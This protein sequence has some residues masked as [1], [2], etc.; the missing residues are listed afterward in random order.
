MP[1]LKQPNHP[2]AH[3][4][5][6][7][8][9]QRKALEK[10]HRRRTILEAAEAVMQESGLFGLNIDLVAARTELAKGTIYLYFKSK[11]E[12]LA[13]LTLKARRLLVEAFD[14]VVSRETDPLSAIRGIIR[15][16]YTFYQ[17][18]ALYYDLVSLYQAN[19]TLTETPQL[20][21][22]SKAIID[23][24]VK[25][26]GEAKTAGQVRADL[27]PVAFALCLWG[28]TVGMMQLI[29]VKSNLVEAEYNLKASQLI[30]TYVRIMV[31][32]IA[33]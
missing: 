17:K 7:S 15:A 3:R 1:R 24:V 18:N 27:D 6:V 19:N 26:V 32:G 29:K 8:T 11:E 5:A 14:Q 12:I 21:E 2:N 13:A 16:N 30:D 20:L 25:L 33:R 23:L 28:M 22:A 9:Q 4:P 10:E 31:E